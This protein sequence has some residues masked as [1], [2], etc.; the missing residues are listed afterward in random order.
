MAMPQTVQDRIV[1]AIRTKLDAMVDIDN[2]NGQGATAQFWNGRGQGSIVGADALSFP[3]YSI[4]QGPEQ[5]EDNSLWPMEHKV[6][7][8]YIEWAFTP[9]MDLDPYTVFRYYLGRL[10]QVLFGTLVNRQLGGLSINVVETNNQPQ[11]ES[12]TDPSPGGLLTFQVLYRI[13]QGDPYHLPSETS[14]YG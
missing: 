10:Q 2:I 3:K 5:T 12:D 8:L 1:Q 14:N 9:F 11:I 6:L 7:T 4:E 13:V